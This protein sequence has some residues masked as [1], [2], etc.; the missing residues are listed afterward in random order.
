MWSFY[1]SALLQSFAAPLQRVFHFSAF[2]ARLG[3]TLFYFQEH[4]RDLLK[5]ILS[6]FLF[7]SRRHIFCFPIFKK[8]LQP[9]LFFMFGIAIL[10]SICAMLRQTF[11]ADMT[12]ARK[13]QRLLAHIS[14]SNIK[15]TVNYRSVIIKKRRMQ[16]TER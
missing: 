14:T 5:E 15:Q 6:I 12:N 7:L 16:N 4:P 13:L 1:P 9:S 3:M 8:V 10:V 2:R 11:W